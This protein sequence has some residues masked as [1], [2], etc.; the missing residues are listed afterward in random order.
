MRKIILML[1]AASLAACGASTDEAVVDDEP[2]EEAVAEEAAEAAPSGAT[3]QIGRFMMTVEGEKKGVATFRE[4][5]FFSQ[6]DPDGLALDGKWAMQDDGQMCVTIDDSDQGP[7]CFDV[8]E[9]DE[10]G[11]WSITAPNGEKGVLT[12]YEE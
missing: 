1:G 9:V 6:G 7:V 11:V 2:T 5:G 4:D 8:G 10:N 12:P 3:V